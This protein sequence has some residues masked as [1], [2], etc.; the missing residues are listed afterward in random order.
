MCLISFFCSNVSNI[1]QINSHK[2]LVEH[3]YELFN[4]NLSLVL[5]LILLNQ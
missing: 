5:N 4:Y 2:L 3:T 1:S